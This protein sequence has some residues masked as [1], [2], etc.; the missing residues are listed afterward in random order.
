MWNLPQSRRRVD[1]R[2]SLP[3]CVT[4][5]LACILFLLFT[6][7]NLGEKGKEVCHSLG[8]GTEGQRTALAGKALAP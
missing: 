1:C 7:E 3:S 6:Q 8:S 4:H 2:V 5:T